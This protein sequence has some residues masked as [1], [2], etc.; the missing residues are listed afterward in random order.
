MKT[1]DLPPAPWRRGERRHGQTAG[2]KP[3][4]GAPPEQTAKG[5][6]GRQTG[7]QTMDGQ[8]VIAAGAAAARRPG[9]AG[10]AGQRDRPGPLRAGGRSARLRSPGPRGAPGLR[11][12]PGRAGHRAAGPDHRRDRGPQRR[13]QPGPLLPGQRPARAGAGPLP[14]V[15]A[16]RRADLRP[17][18]R[19]RVRR[20]IAELER[21]VESAPPPGTRRRRRRRPP[22]RP[23]PRVDPLPPGPSDL[24]AQAAPDPWSR[25]RPPCAW[26]RWR[27]RRP[28]WC[29]LVGAIYLRLSG[30][31]AS[32]TRSRTRRARSLPP[33]STARCR[34]GQRAATLQ[35]VGVGL[36][37]AMLAGAGTLYL[38][39]RRGGEPAVS[40]GDGWTRSSPEAAAVPC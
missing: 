9:P 6:T 4:E 2:R 32:R 16:H 23:R 31:A 22:C 18:E 17:R 38:L 1:R 12:R 25:A 10:R 11:R 14:R 7:G 20:F 15:P 8:V 21:E 13:L 30:P 40:P 3:P 34:R 29:P 33:T 26:W 39:S 5:K 24:R 37:G 36:G 27:R 35:W 28:P 19:A